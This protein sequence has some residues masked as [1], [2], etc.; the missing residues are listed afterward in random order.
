M[1]LAVATAAA[2]AAVAHV[3][4]TNLGREGLQRGRIKRLLA[5]GARVALLRGCEKLLEHQ[6]CGSCDRHLPAPHT[7]IERKRERERKTGIQN[8]AVIR[9]RRQRDTRVINWRY[10]ECLVSTG[11][12]SRNVSIESGRRGER[13]RT[14][15]STMRCGNLANVLLSLLQLSLFL[16]EELGKRALGGGEWTEHLRGGCRRDGR[17]SVGVV[18]SVV[19]GMHKLPPTR[20]VES[21]NH[22]RC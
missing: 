21:H 12:I 5:Q 13:E 8:I 11:R 16:L 17:V 10:G 19:A 6:A 9:Q 20:R 15:A 14:G 1:V 22:H 2:T 18:I 7:Y 3:A 4:S